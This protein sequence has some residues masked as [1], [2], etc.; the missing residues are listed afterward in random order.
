MQRVL[1]PQLAPTL[2]VVSTP[3]GN[4]DDM[5][6]RA[7]ETLK[8]VDYIAAEDTRH[9]RRLLDRYAIDTRLLGYHDHSDNNTIATLLGYLAE[10]KSVALISDAGTPLIADP[11]YKLIKAVIEQGYAVVPIPGACAVT[12]ALSVAGLPTD[13][14][15]F[16]GFL[17]AK[18]EA[19]KKR[20]QRLTHETRT[21]VFYEAPHR[22]LDTLVTLLDVFGNERNMVLARELT[23]R[24]ETVL[25]ANI[26]DLLAMVKQD[27]DQQRGEFVLLLEGEA[28][29]IL[30]E[31]HET[32]AML[33][34]LLAECSVKQSAAL[35]AKLTGLKKNYLYQL[36]LSLAD[37]S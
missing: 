31:Q 8:K 14:F 5:T 21:M 25:R 28:D 34:I 26:G 24:F 6:F 9:S 36:A 7:V 18:S 37:K 29:D 30:P 23:K 4:L 15:V 16:E 11:G 17:P 3:I 27:A 20:L 32:E 2:Y 33:N 22:I 10:Q 35:A 1:S 12:S 13:R 19:R